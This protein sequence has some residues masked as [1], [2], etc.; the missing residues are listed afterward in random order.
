MSLFRRKNAVVSKVRGAMVESLEAR[1]YLSVTPVGL[2]LEGVRDWN[3]SFMFVDAMKSARQFGS[4]STPWDTAAVLDANG[5]PTGDAG[6]CVISIGQAQIPGQDV[7][8]IDGVYKF[9]ATGNVTVKPVG[10]SHVSVANRTYD[11]ATNKTTA[12]VVVG[13]GADTVYLSFTGAV[14]GAK[15]I[16]L[17]RP[18]YDANTTQTFTNEFMNSLAGVQTLRMMDVVSTNNNPSVHWSERVK[19][20]D[21]VQSGPKGAAWE[22]VVELANTLDKDIWINMPVAA[23]DDY[24]RSLAS[25][26][27]TTLEP[28]RK[29]YLEYS[30]EVWNGIF[31]QYHTNYAL[32]QQEAAADP[33]FLRYDGTTE[34]VY[35]S[36]RRTA[37]RLVQI[38]DVFAE[39]YGAGAINDTIRPVLAGQISWTYQIRNQLDFLQHHYGDLSKHLYAVAS[40]PYLYLGDLGDSTT[41][42]VDQVIEQLAASNAAQAPYIARYSGLAAYHGLKHLYYE[43]GTDIVGANYE[44]NFKTA[45][46]PAMYDPRMSGIITEWFNQA[47]RNGV[48]HAVFYTHTFAAG[49]SG[50][51]GLTESIYNTNTPRYEGFR[52]AANAPKPQITA[53]HAMPAPGAS[54]TVGARSYL[55]DGWGNAGSGS[56]DLSWTYTGQ[57]LDYL[58]NVGTA[59]EFKVTVNAAATTTTGKLE[60]SLDGKTIATLN[61][62]N[63]GG[64]FK[65]VATFQLGANDMPAVLANGLHT[66]RLK[67]V[68]GGV[69]LRSLTIEAGL[70]ASP[71]APGT[72]TG[73]TA[74]A[75]NSSEI[76]LAWEDVAYETAYVVERSADGV[77]GWAEIGQTGPDV[78]TYADRNLAAGT[79][80]FYRVKA[81]NPVGT[82]AASAVATATTVVARPAAPSGLTAVAN[83]TTAVELNWNDLPDETAYYIERA[84]DAV[85][86]TQIALLAF[87]TVSYVDTQVSAGNTYTYRMRA[88]NV[89]GKS[90]Y[91]SPV[92]VTL[93]AATGVPEVPE[94]LKAAAM[95]GGQIGLSWRDVAGEAAYVIER[96]A[97][98]G[99]SWRKVA[100]LGADS[101]Q[102]LDGGLTAGVTYGYRIR[103]S[104]VHGTSAFG[105]PAWA[106]VSPISSLPAP[107][108]VKAWSSGSGAVTVKWRDIDG[109]R[110]YVVERST[111]GVNW[112]INRFMGANATSFTATELT[113]GT[114]YYFRVYAYENSG[115]FSRPSAVAGA[116]AK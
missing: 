2:N 105:T 27:K 75:R 22:Y 16:K 31:G 5:W 83:G 6:A 106:T 92:S 109:E 32:A 66:L 73:L 30:N 35:I 104:N 87:D 99:K 53:G 8:R 26:L 50:F 21:G 72:P 56:G 89:G 1:Q 115:L 49:Q 107:T 84:T 111:D 91:S 3:R 33:S 45:K 37:A 46:L 110:G 13:V 39:V 57:T 86:F 41:L 51:W 88:A 79:A 48:E 9:S 81:T 70:T 96:S 54:I 113:A 102:W 17:I 103:A 23:T 61:M 98:A 43:G 62:P 52:A 101:R 108:G 71:Q 25:L 11:A 112:V 94:E 68:Y 34:G 20:G 58:L 18:G 95:G 59:N 38:K 97:D 93:A 55:Q 90:D 24:V 82:S 29:V 64:A 7:P 40:A 65:D 10:S 42:T 116:R 15:N 76:N 69:S 63:T 100:T 14:G 80:Y 67:V 85:N 19:P 36:W 74:A 28:E 44:S 77:T 78:T 114:Y 12:D 4:A 47:H 60:L